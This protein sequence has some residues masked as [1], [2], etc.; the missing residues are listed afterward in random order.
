MI[1]IF[2]GSE[3]NFEFPQ[4]TPMI[5]LLNVHFSRFS[6]LERPDHLATTP[7][8]PIE[9]YR[10]GFG[11]WCSRLVAPAGAFTLRTGT[12][13]RDFGLPDP[14]FADAIQHP[15]EQLP[16]ETLQFL[17]AS[18]YCETDALSDEAWRLF[19]QMKPGWSRVQAICDFVHDR[20][21]FG[22]EYSRPTRT[23]FETY[24]ECRGVCR[25]YAHLVTTFCRCLNI[26]TR[27]CTGYV[28]D[29]G[30]PPPYEPMDFAAWIEV[31]LGGAGAPS[32]RA[33]TRRGSDVS[34]SGKDATPPTCRSPIV[35]GR[36]SSRAL[37]FGRKKRGLHKPNLSL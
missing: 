12:I 34:S 27:Y 23:A 32:I 19:G 6:D 24:N 3:L 17:L 15:V 21:T 11:N 26:P 5:A 1:R 8:V 36:T 29:I 33:T 28:T 25:D 22:Y 10:D 2:V 13:V 7:S 9:D 4:P 37:K 18:R 30:L 16:S 31:Y 14:V 35:S 20:M